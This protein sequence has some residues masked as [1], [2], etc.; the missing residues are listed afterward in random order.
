MIK[1]LTYPFRLAITE[2]KKVNAFRK[3]VQ[4]KTIKSTILGFMMQSLIFLLGFIV[5]YYGLAYLAIIA[6]FKLDFI[7]FLFMITFL[8]MLSF[9]IFIF[10]NAVSKSKTNFL[11]SKNVYEKYI[12]V[13]GHI[14]E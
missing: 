6:I 7:A 14:G 2:L 10:K 11:K 3:A 12:E 1:K 13:T 5:T 4:S 8:L 9:F